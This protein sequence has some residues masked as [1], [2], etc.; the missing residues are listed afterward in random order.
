[1]MNCENVDKVKDTE[2]WC[3]M[4]AVQILPYALQHTVGCW[5][6]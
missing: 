6:H 1:M 2:N 5:G 3:L 4:A